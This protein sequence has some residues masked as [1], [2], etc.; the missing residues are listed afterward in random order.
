MRLPVYYSPSHKKRYT[1]SR[2]RLGNISFEL[3]VATL[4]ATLPPELRVGGNPTIQS[5]IK[6][7]NDYIENYAELIYLK[8]RSAKIEPLTDD[9]C[10]MDLEYDKICPKPFF[11]G[12]TSWKDVPE[13]LKIRMCEYLER[14]FGR[15]DRNPA[16]ALS[17]NNGKSVSKD[18]DFIQRGRHDDDA[19]IYEDIS[20]RI[21]SDVLADLYAE[22]S[23]PSLC[24]TYET[25]FGSPS[26]ERSLT[27]SDN[28]ECEYNSEQT[29]I[30][31]RRS[32]SIESFRVQGN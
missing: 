4:I 12:F 7:I 18:R 32:Q 29:T 24:E 22:Q 16:R 9:D 5:C 11:G 30:E 6:T 23:R 1:T 13:V 20:S 27:V 28:E 14:A 17:L 31:V 15:K 8:V 21:G 2:P 26:R 3:T 25:S 19:S 10:Q